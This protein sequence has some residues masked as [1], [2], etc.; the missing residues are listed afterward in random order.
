[1]IRRLVAALV[2]GDTLMCLSNQT[3]PYEVN[4]GE[5]MKLVDSWSDKLTEMFKTE[6]ASPLRSKRA[7]LSK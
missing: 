7:Y 2:Y 4:K 6:T 3:K 1:M 5:S